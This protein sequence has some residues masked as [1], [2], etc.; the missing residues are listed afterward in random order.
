M[1]PTGGR[2]DRLPSSS[3]YV[4]QPNPNVF[5]SGHLAPRQS[6]RFEYLASPESRTSAPCL[7]RLSPLCWL[8]WNAAT[9]CN[10]M[11]P[12][13]AFP[14]HY[15]PAAQCNPILP[16]NSKRSRLPNPAVRGGMAAPVGAT[17]ASNPDSTRFG[18]SPAFRTFCI[19][20]ECC[21]E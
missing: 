10:I 14:M 12:L 16:F 15:Y 8:Q 11:L 18:L 4:R 9:E 13:A 19:E 3:E 5:I 1:R 17:G 2:P 7:D 20:P 21:T 6:H